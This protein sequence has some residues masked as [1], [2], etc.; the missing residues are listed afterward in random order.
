MEYSTEWAKAK[1]QEIKGAVKVED[2]VEVSGEL[3]AELMANTQR[4]PASHLES[5]VQN[6]EEN[7]TPLNK[8][9]SAFVLFGKKLSLL[10]SVYRY[11][12]ARSLV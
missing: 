9:E 11:L 6:C 1:V 4:E 8:H 2:A 3:T 5:A 7:K 12:S 10:R